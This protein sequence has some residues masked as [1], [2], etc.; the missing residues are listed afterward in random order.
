MKHGIL[1]LVVCIAVLV[2]LFWRAIGPVAK[3]RGLVLKSVEHP[4]APSQLWGASYL[5]R[6]GVEMGRNGGYSPDNGRTWEYLPIKPNFDSKLPRGYRRNEMSGFVDPENGR[7]VKI[8]IAMDTPDL[9][10]T[11]IEPPIGLESYYLRYRVSVD[12]G[13]TFLFDEPVVQ[14]GKTPENPF[15]G[16]F[17]GKNAI[18]LGDAGSQ[19]IRTRRGDIIVPA[20]ACI[21]APDG[22]LANP[23]GGFTWTA[24]LMVIGRWVPDNRLEW[25][26][27]EP[28]VGDPAC[29]TR[30]MIEPTLAEL[31]DG[32]I[33][34]VMRGSNGGSKDPD[35]KL[36]SY[37][38]F[39]VSTDGGFHWSKPEPLTYEDGTPFYSPSSMSQLLKHSS[40]RIFWIGNLSETNCRANDPRY[41][42]V[43]GEVDRKTLRLIRKS[44]LIIDTKLPEESGLN[45]SHFWGLEDRETKDIVI[46]GRRFKD[47]YVDESTGWSQSPPVVYR[48]AVP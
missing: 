9:D 16:V 18:F 8:V 39:A 48:I 37:R 7:I 35:C 33:L 30:G 34:C 4:S 24:A 47:K 1:I 31:P 44:V 5:K 46:V 20:Q 36:P 13:K 26:A 38:W 29:T 41:P 17:R 14:K 6:A 19:I 21:L 22:K 42:L 15:D 10:S 45:L 12:G 23:G 43:I 11:I 32:R 27:S 25:R 2:L 28:I 3:E 40:G